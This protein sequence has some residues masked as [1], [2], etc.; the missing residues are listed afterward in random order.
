MEANPSSSSS[1]PPAKKFDVFLSF[2]GEDTRNNFTG[3][4]SLALR[5]IGLFNIFKDDYALNKGK[6]IGPEL[7]KAIEAS[8]YAVVVLSENYATSSWCLRE[9]AKVVECMGD[10][11]RIRTIFYHVNPSHVRNAAS[12]D[13]QKQKESGFWKALEEHANN[14][15][16]TEYVESW[17]NALVK[18]A[19]QSGHPVEA[20]TDEAIFIKDFVA[21][22]STELGASTRTI[23]GLFGMTSRLKKLDSYVIHPLNSDNVC[24]L[25]IHGMGGIGKS[26]LA[27]A[28]YKKISHK[29]DGNSFLENVREVCEKNPNGLV[30]LQNQLL[31]DILREDFPIG[32][33]GNGKDL[34]RNRLRAKKVLIVLDDVNDSE[35]LEALADSHRKK[36]GSENELDIW[37]GSGSVIIVTTRNENILGERYKIYRAQQLDD[38]EALQLF[39]WK[40]FERIEP[41]DEFKELSEEVVKYASYLPLALKV[42]GS[43]LRRKGKSEWE[44]ALGRLSKCPEKKIIEKLKIS[45]DDLDTADQGIFLDI[46]C[47][48]NGFGK[49]HVIEIMDSCGFD[50][51]YGIS[52]LVDKSLL[53]INEHGK[54]WMHDL[55]KEMGKD[56]GRQSR[57][58]DKNQYNEVL[59]N[60]EGTDQVEAIVVCD[61]R[62]EYIFDALSSLKKLRLLQ[63]ETDAESAYLRLNIVVDCLPCLD[64]LGHYDVLPNNLQYLDWHGFPYNRLPSSFQPHKLV[65]LK[66][67]HSNIKQLWSNCM[68]YKQPLY[69]L[70]V[71]D[72]SYSRSFT[73]FEDFKVVPNLEKLILRGCYGLSKIH[74]SIEHLKKLVLLDLDCCTSLKKLPKEINGLASLQ[75]LKLGHCFDVGING[76]A[77]LVTPELGDR[78]DLGILQWLFFGEEPELPNNLQYLDLRGFPYNKLPSGF[79]PL[80]LVRLQLCHSNIKQ[81]WNNC[82]KR[83]YNLKVIDL[84]YSQYFT[85]F[86]DFTVVPYLEEL[87]LSG[88]RKLSE[89]HPS[90]GNL[91][92][93]ALLDM[94]GCESIEKLPEEIYC[95]ASLQTLK[96][97]RCFK[98]EKLA[99]NVEQLKSLRNLDIEYSGI[100]QLPSSIFLMENLESVS[101]N[102]N[103]I[104]SG[105]RENIISYRTASKCF[106]PDWFCASL[107][108]L[109]LSDCDL[110]GPDAFPEYF[111]KLLKLWHLDLSRNPLSVLPPRISGLSNLTTLRLEHCKNLKCLEAEILPSSLDAVYVNYC[112]SLASFL[113]PLKPCD[114]RCSAYCLDCTELVRRQ[115]G[116][117][118]ALATLSR[119]LQHLSTRIDS[120]EFRFVVPHSDK[121]LPSWF[122]NQSPTASISIKLDPNWHSRK[123]IGIAMVF[124]CRANSSPEDSVPRL[125]SVCGREIW[126]FTRQLGVIDSPISDHL[127]LLYTPNSPYVGGYDFGVSDC[128]EISFL[129]CCG[130]CGVRLVYE[131]DIRELEEITT[132]YFNEQKDV[133]SSHSQSLTPIV[134]LP[135]QRPSS[136]SATIGVEVK[137]QKR[138]KAQGLLSTGEYGLFQI[139]IFA[140]PVGGQPKLRHLDLADNSSL[141][142]RQFKITKI[143]NINMVETM[144]SSPSLAFHVKRR[145]TEIVVPAKATPWELNKLSDIDDQEGMGFLFPTKQSLSLIL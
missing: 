50:S 52:N 140:F 59:E 8:Q 60:E 144:A 72:L 101:G 136:S 51:N 122:I 77:L 1:S 65:Q 47:F 66:L 105:V 145:E 87:I 39:S 28:Y 132:Q 25:G 85:K 125:V 92:K 133:Q 135:A 16:H 9:L 15:S 137:P 143:H 88:C 11:G 42:L 79:Q 23:D 7:I 57:I 55:L 100:K 30:H 33:V 53:S 26:T 81:L 117:M 43:L 119:F 124:C 73:K 83:L 71:I 118:T 63:I 115:D 35:Q 20:H 18:V 61:Q 109:N 49:N 34:I 74:P 44:S 70:K 10:S 24:F 134:V 41:P 13:V 12:T 75:T 29:F 123:L 64:G 91:E 127:F 99:D 5:K 78:L 102:E 2:R 129:D 110:T 56:M 130:S 68:K 89:I 126:G 90:I 114:L 107:R 3:H 112:T 120:W 116:G 97:C 80:Q 131:E 67:P 38:D 84:S 141:I 98:L 27:E 37:F 62:E 139:V 45:F 19:N 96:L 69:S 40:A 31:K 32:H 22:I 142:R 121:K 46:A 138:S 113:D 128:L 93:L 4:L 104:Q 82:N 111:G 108:M 6:D 103:I 58:W 95:L 17:R 21:N 54:I 14:P 48:F 106:S 76:L 36:Q 86:D 94:E